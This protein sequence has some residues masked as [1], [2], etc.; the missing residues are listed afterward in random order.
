MG[1]GQRNN[2]LFQTLFTNISQGSDLAN[3]VTKAIK[4]S[5]LEK[6]GEKTSF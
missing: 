2:F 1:E 5:S 4:C 6:K 3:I